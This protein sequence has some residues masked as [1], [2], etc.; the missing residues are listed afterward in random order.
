MF[1]FLRPKVFD[2]FEILEIILLILDATEE[3]IIEFLI[4]I[5]KATLFCNFRS[6]E[7]HFTNFR[8]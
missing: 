6:R 3:L 1:Q 5:A 7:K 8:G 2:N 4:I